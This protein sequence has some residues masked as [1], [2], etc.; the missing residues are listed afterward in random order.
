LWGSVRNKNHLEEPGLDEEIILK[1]IIR[2]WFGRIYWIEVAHSRNRRWDLMIAV[3][4]LTVP[5]SARKS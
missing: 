5:Q 2:K 4:I 3:M 1:W